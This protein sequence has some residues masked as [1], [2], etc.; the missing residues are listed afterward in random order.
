MIRMDI[1][2]KYGL[3]NFVFEHIFQL[4]AN[5]EDKNKGHPWLHIYD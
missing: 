5:M 3:K 2:L 4:L 1:M